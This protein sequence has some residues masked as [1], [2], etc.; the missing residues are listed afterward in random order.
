[1]D[2]TTRFAIQDL[3]ADYARCVD[4][5][6]Y[7]EWPDFFTEQ[8]LYRTVSRENYN[9]GL[10]M[11]ALSLESRAMLKDRVYG[12]NETIFHAPYYQRHI[13]G[14]PRILSE[15]NGVIVA[16]ANY[17]V[18]R[19]KLDAF[20]EVFNAGRY[21]DTIVNDGGRLKFRQRICVFD[22][23]LVPNSIVYPL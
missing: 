8:C 1:M 4:D 15:D 9:A 3:Y 20:S 23:D 6:R 10:P 13:V 11:S 19:T 17:L 12:M 5:S 21:I 7:E 16:E 18:I 14:L 22:S 2:A